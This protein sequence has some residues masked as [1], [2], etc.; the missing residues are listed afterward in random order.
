M[1]LREVRFDD[2]WLVNAVNE[3]KAETSPCGAQ[4]VYSE[5]SRNAKTVR[6]DDRDCG[7]KSVER[8]HL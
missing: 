7:E 4:S 3:L 8:I 5:Y 2:D 1:A 6:D